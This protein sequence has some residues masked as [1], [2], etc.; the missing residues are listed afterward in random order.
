[1]ITGAPS[2]DLLFMVAR[3]FHTAI[4]V[5]MVPINVLLISRMTTFFCLVVFL[6]SHHA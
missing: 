1:M 3:P 2:R 6:S 4:Q 5:G